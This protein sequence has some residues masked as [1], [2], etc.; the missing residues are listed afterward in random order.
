LVLKVLYTQK[1]QKLVGEKR[2]IHKLLNWESF[3]Y[4]ELDIQEAPY[5]EK[6]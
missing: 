2:P 3:L 5:N 6:L 1:Q 4:V